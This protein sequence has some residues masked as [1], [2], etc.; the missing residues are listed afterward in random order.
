M[1]ALFLFGLPLFDDSQLI[2]DTFMFQCRPS[3][4]DGV[5]TIDI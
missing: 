1:A 5:A 3:V 4:N 2:C